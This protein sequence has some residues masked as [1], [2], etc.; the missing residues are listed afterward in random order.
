MNEQDEESWKGFPMSS[1][2]CHYQVYR[3]VIRQ[4]L[5]ATVE[6]LESN[7]EP[8]SGN[9]NKKLTGQPVP[10]VVIK[11]QDLQQGIFTGGANHD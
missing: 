5:G 1:A 4:A 8:G 10:F 11:P 3:Q 7:P 2:Y 6:T 9:Y